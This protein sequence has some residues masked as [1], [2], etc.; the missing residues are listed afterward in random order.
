MCWMDIWWYSCSLSNIIS[1]PSVI[2]GD[3]KSKGNGICS[4]VS[5]EMRYLTLSLQM[6]L[7]FSWNDRQF[8]GYLSFWC[9]CT[10]SG[11]MVRLKICF[12]CRIYHF[13]W[14]RD[15]LLF[16]IFWDE[17]MNDNTKAQSELTFTGVGPMRVIG[18]ESKQNWIIL[19]IAKVLHSSAA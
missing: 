7:S 14:C 18:K 4:L 8:Q 10:L 17:G 3:C 5:F 11:L 2:Y 1:S 16:M 15:I 19:K 9:A 6:V 12:K 13:T